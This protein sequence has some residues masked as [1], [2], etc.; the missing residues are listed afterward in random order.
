MEKRLSAA[1]LRAK[2]SQAWRDFLLGHLPTLERWVEGLVE[3]L[4]P[5]ASEAERLLAL[6]LSLS[7]LCF[8]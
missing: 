2:E 3:R 4:R 1:E 6:L 7:C 8:S 5:S